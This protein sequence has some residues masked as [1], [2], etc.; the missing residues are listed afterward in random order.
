MPITINDPE[1][2]QFIRE[3]AE[4]TEVDD[5]E[6]IRALVVKH[7]DVQRRLASVME[8]LRNDVWPHIPPEHL[9]KRIT[10]EEKAVLLGYGPD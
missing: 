10:R 6:A 5:V 9:G 1:L 4:E 2:E 3:L 8:W 7:R